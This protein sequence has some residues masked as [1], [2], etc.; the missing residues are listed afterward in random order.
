MRMSWHADLRPKGHPPIRVLYMQP[1]TGF[2]GAE[3]QASLLIPH[4]A[5]WGV[6]ALPLVGPSDTVVHWMQEQEIEEI[7]HSQNFPGVLL[8]EKGLALLAR[9]ARYVRC[10]R[11]VA[12]EV[13]RLAWTRSMDLVLAATPFS[14]L[15]AT[16]PARRMGIPIVW[17]AGGGIAGA[18]ERSLLR[19]WAALHPPDLL[20]CC[21]EAVQNALAPLVSASVEVVHNGVDVNH[22]RPGRGTPELYRPPRAHL[23]VG[24][25]AR[26]APEK[27]TEEFVEMAARLVARRPGVAFLVAGDGACR[28]ICEALARRRGLERSM[29]FL[30][31]VADMRSFYAACDVLVLPSRSEGLPNVVLEAMAMQKPVVVS[32]RVAETGV[33]RHHR[34]GLVYRL[35]D[36][37]AFVEAVDQLLQAE[38]LRATLARNAHDRVRRSFDVHRSGRKMARMLRMLVAW[39]GG[40]APAA[41]PRIGA[42]PVRL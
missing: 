4:L 6:E 9:P 37:F 3:R 15:A 2:G 36:V 14:W 22:F 34:E 5:S 35:G 42:A 33:L 28:Q 29:R 20:I 16:D 18:V 41:V 1:S 13:Q 26:L 25:A 38:T 11:Q 12:S 31:Y 21:S 8:Q 24:M 17:W 32:D 7:V 27:R 23:V 10:W 30:G 19:A 40:K 39:S